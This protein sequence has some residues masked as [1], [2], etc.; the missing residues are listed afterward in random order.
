MF[1]TSSFAGPVDVSQLPPAAQVRIEFNRDIQPILSKHCYGCHGPDKQENNLRLD[2]KSAAFKGGD[3]GPVIVAGKSAE[4]RLIHLVAGLEKNLVMPKK[5]E[6][7][8]PEQIGL[9]RAWIDQGANWPESTDAAKADDKSNWW[10]FKPASRQ[11]LPKV[12]NQKWA[13]NPVDLFV[14]A[15]LEAEG[16]SPSPEADRRTLIRRLSFDLTGLP[17]TPD[18]VEAFL[19][20]RSKQAYEKLVDR[21]LA[22]PR[23]GER[24]ARHWL[25]TVHYGETHG[26]DKDKPRLNAWPYRDYVIRALNEDKSYSRFVEEQL[27]GDVLFPD[28]PDGV[29]ALGFIAAGPWDFVGHVELPIEKTDG[30]IARYNDRDDMVMTTIS[31]FQS[32]T[33][34]CARCHNHKFDPISQKDYYSLQAVFAGVDR[35]DRTFDTNKNVLIQRRDLLQKRRPLEERYVELTNQ[36]AK[37]S[38]PEIQELDRRLAKLKTQLVASSGDKSPANGYHSAIEAKPETTKWVQVDFG[39]SLPLDEVRLIPARPVDFPDTPGF[40]FP[41]RFRVEISDNADF[42]TSEIIADQTSVDF[43]NPGDNAVS[44]SSQNKRAR[45]VRVSATKLWERTSDYVFALAELQVLVGGTNIALG[46]TVTALDSIEAGLW[47]TKHL[48]DGFS[49]RKKLTD[50]QSPSNQ[51]E[52]ESEIAALK[53]RRR[54]L[55]EAALDGVTRLELVETTHKL[56]E[57]NLEI[58]ALPAPVKVYAAAS[59]FK[60]EGSFLPAKAPRPVHLLARGDVKRPGDLMSAAGISCVSGPETQFNLSDNASEAA[61]RAA[62]AKWIT[63]PKNLLT[64]RSIVNRVWLHHF[65]RGIV[66]TPNDFG[67]MGA[68][69]T[70]PELLDWLAFWFVDNGESL[71]KLHRLI[72]T[73]AAYRQSSANNPGSAKLDADNRFL[74]RM[75]RVRLDAE[76]IRDSMLHVSGKLDLTT[77]GPSVQQFYFKDDHSPVYDYTRFDVDSPAGNRRSIYRFI[78]RSVPDPLMESLDCPDASILTPKRSVTVTALQAL[79]V[80]N[81]PFVLRQSEHLAAR[82]AKAGDLKKQIEQV[83]ELTLNRQP[84]KAEMKKLLPF[85]EKNGMAGLCRLIFNT[86]EFMFID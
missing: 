2:V 17:P 11:P 40:G 3:S 37:V 62:L 78:V 6:R 66:E 63:D 38:S 28:E 84:T 82:V 70:H 46:T 43:K 1:A 50:T 25:D 30:L 75:N 24:W 8:T 58:A 49:S 31:T 41:A 39:Q 20:D 74:W 65:G 56:D 55:T 21:L 18:E 45:Y 23:Y 14:L 67:H 72:V 26:Y 81:N 44:F 29:A 16:L 68:L 22:S 85:A 64:R 42:A 15:K 32:L 53:E 19:R 60:R 61:R 12:K 7:L 76:T 77:G 73:S 4:S 57:V 35:A 5:G 79:A 69:P 10:S 54:Q 71:K 27:A 36:V 80:L 48:V 33:V 51:K 47:S 59:E 86:S 52:L 83:Y 9:L 34:H 13:C